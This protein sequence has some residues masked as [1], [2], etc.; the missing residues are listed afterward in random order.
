MR[1]VAAAAKRLHAILKVEKEFRRVEDGLTS[2]WSVAQHMG[3]TLKQEY[4]LLGMFDERE[5]QEYLRRYLERMLP[6]VEEMELMKE[7]IRLN[8]HFRNL[9]GFSIT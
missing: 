2:Y 3:L 7:K 4:E 5:R 1:E 6:V 8:G 9:P